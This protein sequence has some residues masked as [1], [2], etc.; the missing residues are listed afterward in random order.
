MKKRFSLVVLTALSLV[1]LNSLA[2][3]ISP[4]I[5]AY[6]GW[7]AMQSPPNLLLSDGE[8]LSYSDSTWTYRPEVAGQ[9]HLHKATSILVSLGWQDYVDSSWSFFEGDAL[10][11]KI[12]GYDLQLSLLQKFHYLSVGVGA[13]LGYFEQR[14]STHGF[15][16]NTNSWSFNDLSSAHYWNPI[17]SL[18]IAI[19]LYKGLS[20]ALLYS[21]VF[22]SNQPD[23]QTPQ[24]VVSRYSTS[25]WHKMPSTNSALIGLQYCFGK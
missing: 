15:L 6:T 21:H 10:K 5:A 17:A 7:S 24:G 18:R 2:L 13:G 22:G 8:K 23:L 12:S 1:S 11:Q 25:R 14:F 4:I 19:P 9:I 20:L 16:S 3:S